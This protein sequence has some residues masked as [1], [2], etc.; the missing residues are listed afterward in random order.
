MTSVKQR[1]R[2]QAVDKRSVFRNTDTLPIACIHLWLVIVRL[3]QTGVAAPLRSAELVSSAAGILLLRGH[4]GGRG[5]DLR[6]VDE[7]DAWL[8]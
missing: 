1:D 6:R 2:S 7:E 8:R 4:R 5:L 3:G